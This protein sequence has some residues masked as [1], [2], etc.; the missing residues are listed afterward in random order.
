MDLTQ[1]QLPLTSF[2]SRA[3]ATKGKTAARSKKAKKENTAASSSKKRK[4]DADQTDGGTT[5]RPRGTFDA[6]DYPNRKDG[7]SKD[8]T[9]STILDAAHGPTLTHG[10]TG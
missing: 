3:L 1:E 10:G 4:A 5:K 6:D 9:V 2:F 7:S 8:N